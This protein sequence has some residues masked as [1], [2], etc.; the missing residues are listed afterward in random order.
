V[1]PRL[2]ELGIPG[3]TIPI[4]ERVEKDR[5][6]KTRDQQEILSLVTLGTH[7]HEPVKT[8][9]ESLCRWWHGP[10][11]NEGWLEVQRLMKFL[12]W[13]KDQDPPAEFTPQLHRRFVEVLME[14]RPW[15]AILMISDLLG[16]NQRFNE[17]GIA[18]DSN[19][20]QRLALPLNALEHEKPFSEVLGWL[21]EAVARSG[22]GA[23]LA[24]AKG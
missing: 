19:W 23:P 11:G 13:P 18:G 3:F 2:K 7:D 10:D 5:S 6:F 15:L 17:P 14:C 24:K 9:Y 22:R 1:R 16:V 12:E 4:F 8:Y 21:D 20:S